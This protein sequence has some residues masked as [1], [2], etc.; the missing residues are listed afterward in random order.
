VEE[1]KYFNQVQQFGEKSLW[2]THVA[3]LWTCVVNSK[4]QAS[5]GLKKII[6]D[7]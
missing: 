5:M 6:D 3:G 4:K 7:A 1:I 2:L